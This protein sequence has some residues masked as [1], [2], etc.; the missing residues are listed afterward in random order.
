MK[1]LKKVWVQGQFVQHKHSLSWDCYATETQLVTASVAHWWKEEKE[2]KDTHFAQTPPGSLFR[3]DGKGTSS[4]A[5]ALWTPPVLSQCLHTSVGGAHARAKPRLLLCS[6]LHGV[7]HQRWWADAVSGIQQGRPSKGN[8][9]D[10]TTLCALLDRLLPAWSLMVI[11]TWGP[12]QGSLGLPAPCPSDEG[13]PSAS[14]APAG[15]WG[16]AMSCGKGMQVQEG[17]GWVSGLRSPALISVQK[18]PCGEAL[19]KRVEQGT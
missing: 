8:V 4:K 18:H 1:Y 17:Q 10:R 15:L 6:T 11:L 19:P 7:I 3:G 16:R 13:C 5:H 14:A 12:G 9:R 2:I